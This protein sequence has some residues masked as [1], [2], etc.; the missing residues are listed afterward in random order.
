MKVVVRNCLRRL[1]YELVATHRLPPDLTE[2]ERRI[3]SA[4]RAY[5]LTGA[6]R[7]AGVIEATTYIVRNNIPGD[8]VECGVWRG[9]SMM[10]VAL[11]LLELG[12]TSRHL[13]LYDTFA[14]M[15]APTD[16]DRD[17]DGTP[18]RTLLDDVSVADGIRCIADLEDVTRNIERTG[19]PASRVTFVRGKVEDTIPAI[20]PEHIALLRLDTDWYAST[21]HELTHLYPRLSTRGVLILDDYGH[22][23]GAREAADEYFA[24]HGLAPILVRLDYTGRLTLKLEA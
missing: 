22:W 10:A 19:Y 9:G 21:K 16:R 6:D 12:E 3:V 18:A 8:F 11:T 13:Y 14:G 1:G 4:A 17:L 20:A 23:Q 5:T 7:L 15:P 24:E 2:R